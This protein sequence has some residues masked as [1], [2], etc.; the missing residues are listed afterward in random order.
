MKSGHSPGNL[1]F[2]RMCLSIWL[3][4]RI[5]EAVVDHGNDSLPYFSTETLG[6]GSWRRVQ[7][8]FIFS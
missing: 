3:W 2:S 4:E 6:V 8:V 5:G 7:L 1:S